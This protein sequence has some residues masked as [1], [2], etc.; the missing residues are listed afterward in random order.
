[1]NMLIVLALLALTGAVDLAN[2]ITLETAVNGGNLE[3]NLTHEHPSVGNATW[4]AVGWGD[5]MDDTY[6]TLCW[7]DSAYNRD[8]EEY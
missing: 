3:L 6:I 2:G 7:T 8:C 1:M 5:N 4:V